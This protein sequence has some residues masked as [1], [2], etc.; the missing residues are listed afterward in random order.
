MIGVLAWSSDPTD[1]SFTPSRIHPPPQTT[2]GNKS[3]SVAPPS[4]APASCGV[5]GKV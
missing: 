1:L 2:R 3:D 4:L 5:G